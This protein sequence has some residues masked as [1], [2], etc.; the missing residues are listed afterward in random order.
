[1]T[2]K[3]KV[4]KQVDEYIKKLPVEEQELFKTQDWLKD[5]YFNVNW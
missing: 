3:F 4:L 5:E 1:M 2:I